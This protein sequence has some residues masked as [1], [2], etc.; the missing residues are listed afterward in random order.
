M[1]KIVGTE[2]FVLRQTAERNIFRIVII[3]VIL[4]TMD[5]FSMEGIDMKFLGAS[6]KEMIASVRQ[7]SE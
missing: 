4:D 6:V 3:D 5:P 7:P 1:G 2:V